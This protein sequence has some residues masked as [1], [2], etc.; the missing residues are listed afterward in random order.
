MNGD[1]LQDRAFIGSAGIPHARALVRTKRQTRALLRSHTSRSGFKSR[2]KSWTLE[3]VADAKP[4][5]NSRLTR[6]SHFHGRLHICFGCGY[7]ATIAP[8]RQVAHRDFLRYK[9]YGERKEKQPAKR[10]IFVCVITLP[11]CR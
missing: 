8:S 4:V 9:T 10:L 3:S 1:R 6:W 5:G 2:V 7:F 11:S